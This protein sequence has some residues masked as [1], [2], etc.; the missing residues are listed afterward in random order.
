MKSSLP[1]YPRIF[2]EEEGHGRFG[3]WLQCNET[4]GSEFGFLV[5]FIEQK[6]KKSECG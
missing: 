4:H 2:E 1:I 3:G 5:P 6:N